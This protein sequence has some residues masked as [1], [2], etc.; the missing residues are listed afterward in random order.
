MRGNLIIGRNHAFYNINNDLIKV[1]INGNFNKVVNPF[2]IK[3]VYIH[4]N[5]NN[6][7]IIGNGEIKFVKF[8]G[9]NNTINIK[10]DSMCHYEDHGNGN[11]L[12][13]KE[14]LNTHNTMPYFQFETNL[15]IF[16]IGNQNNSSNN[17]RVNNFLNN[18]EEHFYIQLPVFLKF[19]NNDKCSLC[20]RPFN[21]NEKVKIYSCKKH[22]FHINCLKDFLRNHFILPLNPPRC[23]KCNSLNNNNLLNITNEPFFPRNNL[24]FRRRGPQFRRIFYNDLT[25]NS[26]HSAPNLDDSSDDQDFDNFEDEDINLDDDLDLDIKSSNGLNQEI[27]DN[28]EISKIK[29]VEKL[30]SDKKKCTICLEDYVNGDNSIALPCIHIF[31]ADCIKTRLKNQN[32]CPIRKF[33]IKYEIEDIENNL[34]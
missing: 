4:G 32:T 29:D 28:M 1:N 19:N 18:L 24:I 26:R 11:L 8:F 9:N 23:P 3:D 34:F 27:I 22:I 5:N 13:L 25:N 16:N 30:D 21:G 6:V 2:R 17:N 20:S 10:N 7:E 14:N 15:N 31:H 33:E 12:I